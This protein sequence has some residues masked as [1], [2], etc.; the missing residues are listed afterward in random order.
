MKSTKRKVSFEEN[1]KKFIE[2]Y[3]R[4]VFS[5]TTRLKTERFDE[6]L[7]HMIAGAG[8]QKFASQAQRLNFVSSMCGLI[9]D[10][11]EEIADKKSE[12]VEAA[13]SGKFKEIAILLILGDVEIGAQNF[14]IPPTTRVRDPGK[15]LKLAVDEME[16]EIVKAI[17][18]RGIDVNDKRHANIIDYSLMRSADAKIPLMLVKRGFPLDL[19][20]LS[21][22]EI[23]GFPSVA[24]EIA[25]S[26][27]FR[28]NKESG[29][30]ITPVV[31]KIQK[32][33]R[34]THDLSILP[35]AGDMESESLEISPTSFEQLAK[36]HVMNF[37]K[38]PNPRGESKTTNNG[39][40]IF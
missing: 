39:G 23:M 31:P 37:N 32:A 17:I 38:R 11:I 24:N 10:K 30:S 16:Q 3:G 12:M 29:A 26:G 6:D 8:Q 20:T 14:H 27:N 21:N 4:K 1:Q 34:A 40:R 28:I 18:S 35:L 2:T 36:E 19:M 25:E 7:L 9:V 15:F 5:L 22:A 33:F 13:I